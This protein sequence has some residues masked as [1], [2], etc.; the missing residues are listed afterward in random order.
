MFSSGKVL[1]FGTSI[2]INITF[3]DADSRKR[4]NIQTNAKSCTSEQVT[5]YL[6]TNGDCISG[7]VL[8]SS[9]NVEPIRYTEIKCEL[10]G[11]IRIEGDT[12]ET[13]N[14]ICHWRVLDKNGSFTQLKAFDYKF[15]NASLLYESYNGLNVTVRYFLRV[16]LTRPFAFNTVE[17][18]G[19]WVQNVVEESE[20]NHSLKM[21]VGIEDLLHIEF[22]YNKSKYHLEDAI[23]GSQLFSD[24]ETVARFEIMDGTPFKDESIPVRLFLG[25]LRLSPTYIHV[26]DKFSVRNFLN[27]VLVD[28][29]DRRYYKQQE[30]TLWRKHL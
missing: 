1:G 3:N 26:R 4:I 25:G 24:S 12:K 29:D 6:F 13:E 19:F 7:Q 16:T 20:I 23:I 30:V 28:E 11:Q 22:E 15:E 27:L 2:D 18:Q 10:V 21:E 9:S 8:V 14:F 17:E 5:W